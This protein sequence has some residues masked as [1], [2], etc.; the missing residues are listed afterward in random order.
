MRIAVFPG[1]FAPFHPGHISV[2]KKALV[3]FDKVILLQKVTE[4]QKK[5]KLDFSKIGEKDH[6]VVDI[7]H[8]TCTLKEAIKR[9]DPCAVIVGLRSNSDFEREMTSQFWYQ[10]LDIKVPFV[11]FLSDFNYVHYDSSTIKNV[12]TGVGSGKTSKSTKNGKKK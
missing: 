5:Y 11:Y 8:Y 7:V 12:F 10:R 3:V 4:N 2:L 1:K 9:L 6:P